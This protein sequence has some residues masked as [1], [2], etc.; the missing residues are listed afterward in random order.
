MAD[1]K[2][3]RSG[4]VRVGVIGAGVFGGYH[5]QKLSTS[6]HATFVGAFDLSAEAARGICARAGQGEAFSSLDDLFAACDAVVIATPA[7][8]HAHLTRR[9]LEAGKHALVEKP[10][11]LTGGEA[12][13]LARL[14]LERDLVLQVG[15]Q[16]RLIFEAMGLFATGERPHRIEAVR[17]NQ[18]S[19][20]GRCE[21]VSVVFDLMIHD[22]DLAAELM[23]GE[24][25]AVNGDGASSHTRF[26]DHISADL[27]FANG[28]A[29][30]TASR[31]AAERERR[32]RI[33]YSCGTV[34][35]D[36]LTRT[37]RNSTPFDIR[38]DVSVILPDPLRAADE[39]F[40]AAIQ[41]RG[42]SRITGG[43]GARAAAMAETVETGAMDTVAA[44]AA[45]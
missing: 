2:K 27:E 34:E 29:K 40:L 45:A 6:A 14:A 41:G 39:A 20:D 11:A 7:S 21:D 23:G 38:A 28:S 25:T 1:I 44:A 13:A 4:R 26:L 30:L 9:A 22:L 8:T 10:L 32:M 33:E 37:V 24:V 17:L 15:H 5:A 12:R 42:A 43:V 3:V 16:E 31:C 19:P 35:I 18:R 36:F